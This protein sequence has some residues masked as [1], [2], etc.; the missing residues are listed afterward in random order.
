M[1]VSK[2]FEQRLRQA[3]SRAQMAQQRADNNEGILNQKLM[4]M[5]KL[6]GTLTQQSKVS[7]CAV[8]GIASDRTV[9][10]CLHPTRHITII[11]YPVYGCP[12]IVIM[13]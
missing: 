2:Q 12:C 8:N 6:Q 11:Q 7:M 4:E 9:H 13:C 3:E 10:K 5:S 1:D